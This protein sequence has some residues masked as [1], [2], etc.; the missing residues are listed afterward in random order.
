LTNRRE[1][2]NGSSTQEGGHTDLWHLVFSFFLVPVLR[3]KS[4]GWFGSARKKNL[5]NKEGANKEESNHAE[6]TKLQQTGRWNDLVWWM[7]GIIVGDEVTS[8]AHK[9][10]DMLGLPKK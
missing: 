5:R 3:W 8:T 1:N 7:L 9:L 10:F 2:Q 6:K 4:G